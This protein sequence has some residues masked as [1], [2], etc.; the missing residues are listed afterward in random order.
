MAQ[1]L[2]DETDHDVVAD[3]PAVVH[4]LLRHAAEVGAFAN[5]ARSMSPVEM[6]GTTKWRDRRTH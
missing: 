4:D 3:Q 5:A 1:S 2:V 6:C